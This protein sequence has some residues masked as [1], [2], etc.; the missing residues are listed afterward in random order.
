EIFDLSLYLFV[1]RQPFPAGDRV[2]F[3]G[4]EC[5]CQ[6]CTQPLPANSPAPIQ[7]VHNCCGCG[8]EFKNEQS[9]VALDKHWHLG[10]FKCKVCSKVLNAEYISKDGIPFC[11]M[12]YHAMFGIQCESCKKYITGKVLEVQGFL[13]GRNT[14]TAV[15]CILVGS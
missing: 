4:K 11:E 8:K 10:C 7:A 5:I 2:T 6:K 12:D 13:C 14:V 15:A 1:C 9:L 3:N